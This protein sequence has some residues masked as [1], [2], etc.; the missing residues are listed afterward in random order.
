MRDILQAMNEYP[1]TAFFLF[2]AILSIIG[3]F[4]GKF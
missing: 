2:L 3:K 1:W 4:K